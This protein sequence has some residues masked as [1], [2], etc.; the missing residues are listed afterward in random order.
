MTHLI[1]PTC[2]IREKV[3][4]WILSPLVLFGGRGRKNDGLGGDVL[5]PSFNAVTVTVIIVHCQINILTTNHKK[6][7]QTKLCVANHDMVLVLEWIM[8]LFHFV[9][10]WV[11]SV[12]LNA[13]YKN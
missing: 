2:Q 6:D 5:S 10:A 7:K 4:S 11:F 13:G 3:L 12:S 8:F 9:V 1:F